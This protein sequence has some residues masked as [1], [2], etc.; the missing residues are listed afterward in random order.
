MNATKK[1]EIYVPLMETLPDDSIIKLEDV[2]DEFCNLSGMIEIEL[3]E[4]IPLFIQRASN[5]EIKTFFRG[6]K[7]SLIKQYLKFTT[8]VI[9]QNKEQVEALL[10]TISYETQIFVKHL[11]IYSHIAKPGAI[12]SREGVIVETLI[13]KSETIVTKRN[14]A[15]L[16]NNIDISLDILRKYEW[17]IVEN[18]RI[19]T[20]IAWL[21]KHWRAFSDKPQNR[22]QRALN[23]FSYLLHDSLF[24]D[25]SS[26]LF[27][28]LL[29]IEA[30]YVEGNVAV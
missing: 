15:M 23:A 30:L 27:Y 26:D 9:F 5:L 19:G 7:K 20:T 10:H 24:F 13:I 2:V 25:S 14:F 12:D 28:S 21:K 22:I 1:T 17:P 11:L 6:K 16:C 4:N 18:Y 3:H 29:G 8:S